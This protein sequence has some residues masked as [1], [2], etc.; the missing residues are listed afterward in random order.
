MT[1]PTKPGQGTPVPAQPEVPSDQATLQMLVQ[2]LLAERQD[3]LQDKQERQR[4]MKERDAQRKI[5]A[6]YA[7]REKQKIQAM[8]THKKGGRGL[9]S[10]KTDYAV[11]FHTFTD[12]TSYIR[13]QIC[14]AKWRNQDTKEHLVR[15]G[16]QI[17]NHTG[18]G[19]REAYE[20][21]QNSTNTAS[22]S[23]IQIT[24]TPI[25]VDIAALD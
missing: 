8:C 1:D 14:G 11:Y 25:P 5:N 18:I 12:A 10:P 21:L 13:C 4:A 9:K 7:V 20:M 24:A 19:W 16:K 22:S 6:D 2:L 15:R 17:P 23:E 3:A